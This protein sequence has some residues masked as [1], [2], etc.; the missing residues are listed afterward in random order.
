MVNDASFK[1]SQKVVDWF[2][3]QGKST[4]VS[5]CFRCRNIGSL[6]LRASVV[7]RCWGSIG[8]LVMRLLVAAAV[9]VVE[10]VLAVTVVRVV[11]LQ[12]KVYNYN[13]LIKLTY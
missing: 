3:Q 12:L 6:W 9:V 4:L 1:S 5:V 13:I 7:G 2:S 10:V 8:R 11:P